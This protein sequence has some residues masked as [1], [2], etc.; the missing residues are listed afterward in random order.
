M[1]VG[2]DI[3]RID[4]DR[5]LLEVIDS[6]VAGFRHNL[7]PCVRLISAYYLI[8]LEDE[9][10]HILVRIV[11]NLVN[12]HARV[13]LIE[14]VQDDPR[15][16]ACLPHGVVIAR[17]VELGDVGRK[18]HVPYLRQILLVLYIEEGQVS[19]IRIRLTPSI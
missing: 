7:W 11:P 18:T 4:I 16:E 14:R 17:A 2:G 1:R 3:A 12:D 19:I 15:I 8:G 9:S 5:V 10:R 13:S 6:V